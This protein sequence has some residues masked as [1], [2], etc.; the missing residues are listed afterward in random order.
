LAELRPATGGREDG[1]HMVGIDG[2]GRADAHDDAPSP[3]SRQALPAQSRGAGPGG[4]AAD[5]TLP[6]AL[7]ALLVMYGEAYWEYARLHL[8]NADAA[9]DLVDDVFADLAAHWDVVLRQ[10]NVQ[11][12]CWDV[13]RATVDE[14]LELRARPSA[15]T[16]AAFT[17]AMNSARD[18]FQ[19]LESGIGLF[20]AI[21]NLPGRQHDALV[22]TYVLGYPIV[23]AA[24]LMGITQSGVYSLR[25]DARRRLA[26]ALGLDE[27]SAEEA[28]EQ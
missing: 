8:G 25:R 18:E 10:E 3:Q 19:A 14:A 24:Q 28:E 12:F 11:E 26:A 7:T 13:L 21:G 20:A 6:T 15:F 23:T 2:G 4:P 9:D 27:Q 22:L 17:V 16:T 1:H 5:G